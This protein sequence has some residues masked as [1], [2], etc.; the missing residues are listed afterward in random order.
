M[1]Q[2]NILFQEPMHFCLLI[3]IMGDVFMSKE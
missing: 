1:K 3:N 2:K